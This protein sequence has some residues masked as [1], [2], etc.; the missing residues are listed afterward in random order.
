MI[1]KRLSEI[2]EDDL[3]ALI[4]N[5]VSEGRTIDYKRELPAGS[6]GDKKEYLELIRK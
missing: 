3:L 1:Q 6:D 4:R 2:T 5:G